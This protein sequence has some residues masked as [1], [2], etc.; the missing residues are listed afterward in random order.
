[1]TDQVFS[2]GWNDR[3]ECG[4]ERK[5]VLFPTPVRILEGLEIV[6]VAAGYQMTIFLTSE[7]EVLEIGDYNK[8]GK[9]FLK[10]KIPESIVNIEA[11]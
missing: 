4:L 6:Q 2:M 10:H 5:D 7:G 1:M 11:G 9:P 3:K 8:S